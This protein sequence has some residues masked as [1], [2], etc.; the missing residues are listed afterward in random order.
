MSTESALQASHLALVKPIGVDVHLY[1]S[2]SP[3]HSTSTDPSLVILCTWLGGS[4]PRRV[5]KYISG[6]NALFPSSALLVITARITE[7]T[8]LPFSVL[9]ARL[10]P[11]R[12]AIRRILER[13]PSSQGRNASTLLHIFS[14]GGCNT[15]IQL[16]RSLQ[17][18]T[19]SHGSNFDLSQYINGI[20]FDC[21]PGDSSFGRSYEAAAV[22]LPKSW[23]INAAGRLLLYPFIGLIAALQTSGLMGSIK[24]LR[25][26]LNNSTLFGS[27]ARRLYLYSRADKMVRW[28]DVESHL[29]E[30]KTKWGYTAAGM[31]FSESAH[32]AIVR[33]HADEYWGSIRSL[34]EKLNDAMSIQQGKVC[35]SR[36]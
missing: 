18:H 30:A 5:N 1:E 8:V 6:Y 12:D 10:E 2:S 16:V 15:A 11:A 36:L 33:E 9:H 24:D 25:R 14:H 27:T 26:D 7:I 22:S 31:P 19:A 20:I 23:P 32:C 28:E 13:N 34:W 35:H 17:D 4:S 3:R 21:C 29:E